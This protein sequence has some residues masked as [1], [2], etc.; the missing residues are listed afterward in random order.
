VQTMP[1]QSAASK[2]KDG[3][4]PVVK[5][6][7]L[8]LSAADWRKLRVRAAEGEK[9]MQAWVASIIERELASGGGR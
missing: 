5:M 8:N 4:E 7:R 3:R 2:Q 6:M 1:T 9:S